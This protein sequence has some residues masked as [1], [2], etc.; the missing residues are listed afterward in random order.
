VS[1]GDLG[2]DVGGDDGTGRMGTCGTTLQKHRGSV[3]C[4]GGVFVFLL[5]VL[6][7]ISFSY[8]D[9]FDYG[10]KQRKSTGKVVGAYT[11]PLF[12]SI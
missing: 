12:S 8:I 10:L 3:N 2:L 9:Y 4:F 5:L 1:R 7:P 11:R 6:V